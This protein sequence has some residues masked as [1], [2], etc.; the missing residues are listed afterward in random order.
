M[1]GRDYHF[2]DSREQMERDIQNH[3]FIEAGQYSDNLY[4]T[5]I[6]AVKEVADRVSAHVLT[7]EITLESRVKGN[8]INFCVYLFDEF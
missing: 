3:M 1:N 4:G 8:L 5:S 6:A 2:M 7:V